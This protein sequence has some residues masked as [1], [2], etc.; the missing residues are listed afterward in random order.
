M[1]NVAT[2]GL[3]TV[4]NGLFSVISTTREPI[5]VIDPD[6]AESPEQLVKAI[7]CRTVEGLDSDRFRTILCNDDG[8]VQYRK[9]KDSSYYRAVD[10]SK[11]NDPTIYLVV[12]L[13]ENYTEDNFAEISDKIGKIKGVDSVGT[14]GQGGKLMPIK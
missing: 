4:L 12:K 7:Q 13:T 2:P 3:G 1:K 9:I 8:T 11:A 6:N 5:V 10:P 14:R